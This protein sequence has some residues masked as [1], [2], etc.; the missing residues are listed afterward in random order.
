MDVLDTIAPEDREK[1][2]EQTALRKTGVSSS[3]D[4]RAIRKDGTKIQLRISAVP[5]R[6]NEGNIIGTIGLFSDV[7]EAKKA[8]EELLASENRY[9]A[10]IAQLPLGIAIADLTEAIELANEAMAHILKEEHSSL[11]GANL[12]NF[13]DPDHLDILRN[14]TQT[15]TTGQ[16]STYE[17][18][19]L[20]SDDV[21]RHVRI[22][23]AP[24]YASDGSVTG[25]VGVFEDITEQKLND[26]IRTQHER[27]IELYGSLMRHD[28]RNDLG[29]VLSYIEAVQMLLE[30]PGDEVMGFTESAISTVE[31]MANLLK[32]FGRPQEV[33]QADLVEFIE[34]IAKEAQEAEAELRITVAYEN[35]EERVTFM[36]GGL[37]AMVFINLFRN[38]AQHA[39]PNPEVVVLVS[40][41]GDR[42][43]IEVSDSGPGIPEEF[44]DR[45]FQRGTSSKGEAGGLGLHLCRE[46]LERRGGGIEAAPPQEG[47]GAVFNLVIPIDT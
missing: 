23:A 27:Q 24:R 32:S 47:R 31:R 29:L 5:H 19:M 40:R 8:E 18:K 30:D 2:T 4:A 36:A 35:P 3:Y 28:L 1:I 14:Q 45:L 10:L 46:I 20:R 42:V 22:S 41:I 15:R 13:I 7:T 25:S 44:R 33:R 9:K 39:S 16:S 11:I 26:A 43:E 6:D 17:V 38:A 21:S 37:I 34:E 12:L